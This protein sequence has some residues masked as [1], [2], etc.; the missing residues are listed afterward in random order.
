[1]VCSERKTTRVVSSKY[2][3]SPTLAQANHSVRFWD[4][5]CRKS[6][7]IKF[8][9]HVLKNA[10]DKAGINQSLLPTPLT[11]TTI[12]S[13]RREAR[14]SLRNLQKQHVSLRE[15]YL[16]SLAKSRVV[17]RRGNCSESQLKK[18]IKQLKVQENS[19]RKFRNIRHALNK[20][21]Q[22]K[23]L[24]RIDIPH[25]DTDE[26]YPVGPDPK[27][28]GGPWKSVTDPIQIANHVIATNKWQY[29]QAQHTPF[30]SDPLLSLFGFKADQP[31]VDQ[32]LQGSFD[33]SLLPPNL[34]PETNAILKTLSGPPLCTTPDTQPLIST[35]QFTSLYKI[36]NEATS[37]SPS[38]C[39]L[40]H[41]KVA[42][43]HDHLSSL[44]AKMMSIPHIVGFSPTRW[45]KVIDIMLEKNQ[46][47]PKVHHLRIIALLE[48]DF[49]Q[50][51]QL[52]LARPLSW[53]LEDTNT[54]RDMQSGSRKGKMCQSAVLNKHLVF[55]LIRNTEETAIF[56][57]NDAV[58][59]FDRIVNPLI[60]MFLLHLGV[61]RTV[62]S[63]L[64][65]TWEHNS[66]CPHSIWY[67]G[68]RV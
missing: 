61:P 25:G 58:G 64:A 29:S 22:T 51:N 24:A 65:Q 39:H 52:L 4:M 8:P 5:C 26:P 40:G 47:D 35:H 16:S 6:L 12:M 20:G 17:H 27:L 59:C 46:G 15:T 10:A 63:S 14:S 11:Y 41:Y 60:L 55:E 34:F 31:A 62:L 1:M 54:I 38:G 43:S 57:E 45:C 19:R 49:N 18:E 37:S 13:F 33:H 28:W 7:G 9:D 42:S 3:W 56:I 44:H 23:G 67:I 68:K 36:L 2:D 48:S 50:A 30:G 21:L 53:L 66:F 32:L